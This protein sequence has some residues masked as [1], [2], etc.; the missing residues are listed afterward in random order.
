MAVTMPADRAAVKRASTDA[1]LTAI[2]SLPGLFLG[3]IGTAVHSDQLRANGITHVL[4]IATGI[5][6]DVPLS[7]QHKIVAAVDSPSYNILQ[8]LQECGEFIDECL[9]Q[10]KGNVL[11]HC[12]AGRS[13]SVTIV[14]AYLMTRLGMS[15]TDASIAVTR[16]RVLAKP[17]PG[18][19]VQLM[20]LQQYHL[21]AGA[22]RRLGATHT[23]ALTVCRVPV[24]AAAPASQGSRTAMTA[25]SPAGS[26]S[27]SAGATTPTPV[28]R[29][30]SDVEAGNIMPAPL[31]GLYGGGEASATD[32]GSILPTCSA[33]EAAVAPATLAVR[34]PLSKRSRT[35]D[36]R[37]DVVPF[38]LPLAH[39]RFPTGSESSAPPNSLGT[40]GGGIIVSAEEEADQPSP[41]CS[42]T[43]SPIVAASCRSSS[44]DN[45]AAA[46]RLS[47]R[48]QAERGALERGIAS[49]NSGQAECPASCRPTSRFAMPSQLVVVTVNH[50]SPALGRRS[51]LRVAAAAPSTPPSG[52]SQASWPRAAGAPTAAA[53]TTRPT[54]HGNVSTLFRTSSAPS[55]GLVE[56]VPVP[57]VMMKI[58]GLALPADDAGSLLWSDNCSLSSGARL[59][60]FDTAAS[61]DVSP[62]ATEASMVA[63]DQRTLELSEAREPVAVNGVPVSPADLLPRIVEATQGL[64]SHAMVHARARYEALAQ[65][66]AGRQS[67]KN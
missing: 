53:A 5:H 38:A 32:E 66:Q 11:V 26:A 35:G 45:P 61:G 23:A 20:R 49:G 59:A 67:L 43:S 64:L 25:S 41:H 37:G 7:V 51:F 22:L 44:Q 18:F 58:V 39:A 31:V 27:V 40:S 47:L 42:A 12:F 19:I 60:S 4:T 65:Q 3:S 62:L 13:R 36:C 55:R 24:V 2:D 56:P 33:S 10:P 50:L 28:K 46:A 57:L 30:H 21:R 17:N 9:R 14:V 29:F 8:A 52:T 1:E 15:L 54:P 48:I 6:P 34:T 16:C 63:F